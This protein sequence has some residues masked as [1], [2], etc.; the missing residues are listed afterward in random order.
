MFVNSYR[1][2]IMMFLNGSTKEDEEVSVDHSE[3]DLNEYKLM[4]IQIKEMTS[5]NKALT[6]ELETTKK[7]LQLMK[8]LKNDSDSSV[9]SG[10]SS[11]S[12]DSSS[13][14][15]DEHEIEMSFL[16][17]SSGRD[18]HKSKDD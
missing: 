17:R 13:S 5:K 1:R 18:D 4:K 14:S 6:A 11:D 12:S 8:K 3:I 9:D 15:S 2:N 10:S 16:V 7:E